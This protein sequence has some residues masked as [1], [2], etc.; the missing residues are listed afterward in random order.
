[1]TIV[2][3]FIS[4]YGPED[5]FQSLTQVFPNSFTGPGTGFTQHAFPF[6]FSL[7]GH[8]TAAEA[9]WR[10]CWSRETSDTQAT[11]QLCHAD[12]G[13]KNFVEMARMDPWPPQAGGIKAQGVNITA[14]LNQLIANKQDKQ[15]CW[16]VKGDGKHFVRIFVSRL[17]IYWNV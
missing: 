4:L 7:P 9:I 1:M 13:P 12:S 15:L 14:Q 17:E 3:G 11:F 5:G 2:P 8:A 10:I 16:L 6:R